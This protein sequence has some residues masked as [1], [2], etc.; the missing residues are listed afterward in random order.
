[1][2]PKQGWLLLLL[3]LCFVSGCR[4]YRTEKTP[5]H[6]NPN[7]DWQSKFKAQTLTALPPEGTIVWGNKHSFSDEKTRGITNHDVAADV[8]RWSLNDA[9]RWHRLNNAAYFCGFDAAG[10]LGILQ[11]NELFWRTIG[12]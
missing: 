6:L 2:M 5:I 12:I 1:M 4:G 11:S 9:I 3:S 8:D 7:F 10:I